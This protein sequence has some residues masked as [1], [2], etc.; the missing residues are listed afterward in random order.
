LRRVAV[1]TIIAWLLL[2]V[3]FATPHTLNNAGGLL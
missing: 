3:A 1:L 2:V